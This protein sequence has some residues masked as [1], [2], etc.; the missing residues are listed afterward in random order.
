MSLKAF[1][2]FFIAVATLFLAGFGI[3]ELR[4][5]ATGGGA[6]LDW[7]LAVLALCGAVALLVYGRAFLEKMKDVSYL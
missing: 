7:A 2:I 6:S 4:R 3:W 5:L 1:H